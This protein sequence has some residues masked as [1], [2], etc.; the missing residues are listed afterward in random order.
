MTLLALLVK[1]LSNGNGIWDDLILELK[2]DTIKPFVNILVK[3]Q[4]ETDLLDTQY[5]TV[6]KRLIRMA[7]RTIAR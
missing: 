1:L 4:M 5:H 2:L 3:I 6:L 7:S